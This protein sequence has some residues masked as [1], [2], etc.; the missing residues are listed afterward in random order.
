MGNYSDIVQRVYHGRLLAYIQTEGKV[1]KLY[2]KFS[3][4]W[5]KDG[6]VSI[7]VVE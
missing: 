7:E 2:V 6:I 1:E 3:A 4:P 5:L